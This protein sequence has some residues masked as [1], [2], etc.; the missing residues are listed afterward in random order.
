M[1]RPGSRSLQRLIRESQMPRT[2]FMPGLAANA[3]LPYS[4]TWQM[5]LCGNSKIADELTVVMIKR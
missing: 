2:D 4:K 3:L 5:N 1:E